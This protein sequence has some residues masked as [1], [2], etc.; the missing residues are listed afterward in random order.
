MVLACLGCG[1]V[2]ELPNE[3]RDEA[4]T[5]QAVSQARSDRDDAPSQPG[6]T[7]GWDMTGVGGGVTSL[8]ARVVSRYPEMKNV[9]LELVGA[10][11]D[12]LQVV[13]SFGRHAVAS[14]SQVD[15]KV[16]LADLPVQSVGLA[17]SAAVVAHYTA[18]YPTR[19]GTMREVTLDAHGLPVHVTFEPGFGRAAVRT[20]AEQARWNADQQRQGK[21]L[22]ATG[23]R[24]YAATSGR[25][26]AVDARNA[27]SEGLVFVTEGFE[28]L[29]EEE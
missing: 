13:R 19:D 7:V 5:A 27:E 28:P 10:G 18:S 22:R 2:A 24:R 16:P 20:G 3:A 8:T 25:V 6:V 29:E 23:L 1:E 17:S 4:S 14:R 11:P 15:L 9:E 21:Q 12:G 26:E